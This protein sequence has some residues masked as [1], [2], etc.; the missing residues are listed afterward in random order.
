MCCN[1]CCKGLEACGVPA[2]NYPK[3]AYVVTDFVMMLVAMFIM[4]AFRPLAEDHDWIYCNESS[5]GG[6]KCFGTSSILRASFVLF[7]YHI[8]ILLLLIPRGNCASMVHDGF[9][10]VKLTLIFIFYIAS[11]WISNDFFS[12]WANFCRVGS[13]LYLLVQSYF[14]LNFAYIWNDNLSSVME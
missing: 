8:L 2:K 10:T 11:F 14:L 1:C 13:I 7:C 3:A 9:F 12:G 6:D 4:Y 5:G